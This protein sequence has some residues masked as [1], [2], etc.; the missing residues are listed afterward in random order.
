MIEYTLELNKKIRVYDDLFNAQQRSNFY[1]FANTSYFKLGWQDG[2]I[3]ESYFFA[4]Y[5]YEKPRKISVLFNIKNTTKTVF[6]TYIWNHD[7][8]SK[9]IIKSLKMR[10]YKYL[11]II[12]N[13]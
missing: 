2:S 10:F 1:Q 7:T 3:Y 8:D 5:L 4:D 12:K 9:S 6:K 11:M 13:H